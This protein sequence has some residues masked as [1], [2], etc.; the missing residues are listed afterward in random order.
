MASL[1]DNAITKLATVT[2]ID[3]N[4]ADPSVLYPVPSGKSC[5][6]THVVIR[7]ASTSL[8][9]VSISFGFVEAQYDDVIADSTYTEL[10]ADYLY[11][12]VPAMA[13]AYVAQ[14]DIGEVLYV[15]CNTLQGGAATVDIDV[16]GYLF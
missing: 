2:G 15:L 5:V 14:G 6:I 10:T 12:V 9:T 3:M 13:G 11:S 7:N 4:T 1:S 16:L 8:T